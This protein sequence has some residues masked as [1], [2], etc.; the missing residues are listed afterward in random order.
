MLSSGKIGTHRME[1][2]QQPISALVRQLLSGIP[3]PLGGDIMDFAM[4]RARVI[5]KTGLTGKYDFILEYCR[6]MGARAANLPLFTG[7]GQADPPADTLGSGLPNIFA[8]LEK[9]LGLRLENARDIP[10]DVIVVDRVD[11]VPVEN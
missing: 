3:Q 1:A 2:H 7:R 9:Q 4:P 11:R 10:R 6:G 8:A 5:D